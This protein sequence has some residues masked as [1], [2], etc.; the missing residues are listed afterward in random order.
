MSKIHIKGAAIANN[1]FSLLAINDTNNT[2][3]ARTQ[4]IR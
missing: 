3:L 4:N 1:N 2:E